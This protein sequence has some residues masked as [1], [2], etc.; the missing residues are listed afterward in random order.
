MEDVV[1]PPAPLGFSAAPIVPIP[2][3]PGAPHGHGTEHGDDTE[4]TRIASADSALREAEEALAGV[5][6]P[7]RQSR[8]RKETTATAAAVTESQPLLG[9]SSSRLSSSVSHRALDAGASVGQPEEVGDAMPEGLQ[10]WP[11]FGYLAL[12]GCVGGMIYSFYL[13]HWVV[14][15]LEINFMVGPG[16]QALI[17][18]GAKD[19]PKIVEE[20]EWWRLFTAMWLHAGVIHLAANMSVLLRFGWPM[21]KEAGCQRFAPVYLLG[22]LLG[23]LGSA[24]FIP[25]ILS[26]GASGACFAIIGAVWGDLLQNWGLMWSAG[27]CG[28]C[29][30]AFACLSLSTAMNLALGLMPFVDNFAHAFGFLGGLLV[31]SVLMIRPRRDMPGASPWQMVCAWTAGCI[32]LLLVLVLTVVLFFDLPMRDWCPWC[33]YISC[34]E[35]GGLWTCSREKVA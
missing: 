12:I 13:N 20:G 2:Q 22:G 33:D 11:Y 18:A 32:Y 8:S 31:G 26:V 1:A 15:P 24:V 35:I 27:R 25:D 34:V 5:T 19:S 23:S 30:V 3:N 4:M 14:E 9:G 16:L 7:R 29:T 10:K 17:E 21:E 28:Q 6:K